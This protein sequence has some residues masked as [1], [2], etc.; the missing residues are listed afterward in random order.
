MLETVAKVERPE[1]GADASL[2]PTLYLSRTGMLE[3]L[4]QSQVLAYLRGLSSDHAV[5]L[6]S[7]ERDADLANRAHLAQIEAICSAHGIRWV[8]L[9]YRSRPRLLASAWNLGAL[10]WHSWR[11]ARRRK[12]RLIHARSYIP[13]AAAWAVSR[14]TGIPY[15]FDMRSLWPEELITSH[16]LRRGSWLHGVIFR[17]ERRLLAD[18]GIVVSLT[19]AGARYLCDV[20]PGALT[21]ERLRVIPT[22][23][24]LDRFRP[25]PDTRE[26]GPL[27]GCHG[28]LTSGWFRVD[29][30]ATMFDLIAERLPSARFE[31]I[32]RE[33]PA[34][35]LR[36]LDT[37]RDRAA[38]SGAGDVTPGRAPN[39]RS[40][41]SI[42]A[43]KASNIHERLQ[44]QDLSMLFYASGAASELGRSPTRMG[45]VLG[46]GVP[47]V[48][49]DGI[50]D[51]TE[52][53]RGGGVGIVIDSEDPPALVQAADEAVALLQDPKVVR[54]CRQVAE[55]NYSLEAGIDGYREIYRRL[56][57]AD[58]QS[59]RVPN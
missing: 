59:G 48:T 42:S 18:A 49:N 2:P 16:R 32:T 36:A 26:G 10:F 6:I 12:V 44:R 38:S 8:R 57:S 3:P 45:E 34:E 13:A 55:E 51:V 20:H 27:I 33:D 21:D 31:I 11:E 53:V 47:V 50:G 7:F 14:L 19:R 24:D 35:V 23:A 25:A 58:D 46:C 52:I 22:C 4:G 54:R 30:L 9:R 56:S 15:V 5:T 43:A 29:L 1:V 39:W 28:S 17:A 37:S 41:L 40:G